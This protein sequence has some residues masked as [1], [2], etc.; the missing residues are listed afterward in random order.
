M[1]CYIHFYYLSQNLS[2]F[3]E[4]VLMILGLAMVFTDNSNSSK[5]PRVFFKVH[6]EPGEITSLAEQ[7]FFDANSFLNEIVK[8]PS[9]NQTLNNTVIRF[10]QIMSTLHDATLPL[11]LMGY[12]YPD[13]QV[14]TEGMDVEEKLKTFFVSAFSRRDLYATFNGLVPKDDAESRLLD[15]VLRMY[16]K[17][18]MHL[19][20]DEIADIQKIRENL[21][22]VEN[23]FTSNLNNDNT[24][25]ICTAREL[26]GVSFD[27]MET[28]PRT[29]QGM[30]LV[31]TKYPDYYP[32]MDTAKSAETRKRLYSAFVNRQAEHN[33]FLLEE[34]IVLRQEVARKLGFHS[35]AEYQILGRMAETPENVYTFLDVLRDPLQVKIREEKTALLKMKQKAD[36]KATELFPWD[37][38]YYTEQLKKELYSVDTEKIREYFSLDHV[39]EGMFSLFGD[40]FGI[41]FE[42]VKDAPVWSPDVTLYRITSEPD[43]RTIAFVYFDLFPREGKYGHVMMTPLNYPRIDENGT[44]VIPVSAIIGNMQAPTEKR[45]SLLSYDDVETLFHEFGHVLHGSLTSAPYGLL[46]GSNTEWDFVETPSQTFEEWIWIPEIIDTLSGHYLNSSEK[47]PVAIR[48]NLIASRY[49]DMGMVY[50]RRWIIAFADMDYHTIKGPVQITTL[51]DSIYEDLMG[52]QPLPGGHEVATIDHFTGGYDAGYYSYLWSKIYALNVFSRFLN[53]GVTNKTTGDDFRHWILESGNMQDGMA[54]LRGYLGKE[55]SIDPFLLQLNGTADS[56]V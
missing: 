38:R 4:M 46:S 9:E 48:N 5:D 41:R 40:L 37:I 14:S 42:P 6:Y 1:L 47:L 29:E 12:V 17:N 23:M 53:E 28:F 32:V 49:A 21:S 39:K 44:Y 11:I 10:D 2:L 20:D 35:W 16:K 22:N 8:I 27:K 18:G 15:F 26:D 3:K 45:P 31:T 54:L 24:N 34:A 19:S 25:I 7:A 36:P 55:P 50:A 52:I 51:Y 30:Y 43:H 33:T 56:D 13:H